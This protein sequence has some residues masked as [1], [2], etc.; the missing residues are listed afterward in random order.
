MKL[1]TEVTELLFELSDIE[2]AEHTQLLIGDGGF[3]RKNLLDLYQK[4]SN[5]ASHDLIIRIMEKGGYPWFG[6]V[7]PQKSPEPE[8]AMEA[9]THSA[10]SETQLFSEEEFLD[11][12]PANGLFH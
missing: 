4:T 8:V 6:A 11:L 1:T 5:Q 3:L 2:S 9:I 10:V 12:L 7:A